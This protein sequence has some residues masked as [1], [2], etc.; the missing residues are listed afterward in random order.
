MP[1][2]QF[3]NN[4][5]L[6]SGTSNLTHL[7]NERDQQVLRMIMPRDLE[8]VFGNA[9]SLNDPEKGY[10]DPEWYFQASDGCV[11]GIGW[12]WG[13]TRLRGRGNVAKGKTFFVH[14]SP[15]SAAEFMDFLCSSVARA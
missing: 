2:T 13:F 15:D 5:S 4:N 12:R 9:K 10:T 8:K 11:W 7:L 14:P 6:V 1:T 3:I